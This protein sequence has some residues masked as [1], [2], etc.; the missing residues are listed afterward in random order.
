MVKSGVSSHDQEMFCWSLS[1][2]DNKQQQHTW[3][4]NLKG[5]FLYCNVISYEYCYSLHLGIYESD[6]RGKVCVSLLDRK[7]MYKI[8]KLFGFQNCN[9]HTVR[10]IAFHNLLLYHTALKRDN[11]SRKA[12]CL[13][14]IVRLPIG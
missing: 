2:D 4:Y 8:W 13:Q 9:N 6:S 5:C 1:E 10:A 11:R 3:S 7:K 12:S 14:G